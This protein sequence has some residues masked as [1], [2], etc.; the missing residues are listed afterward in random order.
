[1]S[2]RMRAASP[3]I[4]AK[5]CGMVRMP[6]I[7]F[8]AGD[9]IRG[10]TVT[11]VQTCALPISSFLRGLV[12]YQQTDFPRSSP[13]AAEAVRFVKSAEARGEGSRPW[14]ATVA[15]WLLAVA[16]ANQ[17]RFE[18]GRASC[19]ERVYISVDGRGH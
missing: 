12:A 1:M 18:I 3:A 17:R 14:I 4:L 10:G 19:R 8:Q 9:G 6:S 15:K 5:M 11:G 16:F 7:F 13:F 2:G